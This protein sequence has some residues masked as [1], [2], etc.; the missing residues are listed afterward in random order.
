M[1]PDTLQDIEIN[2]FEHNIKGQGHSVD[3]HLFDTQPLNKMRQV[4]TTKNSFDTENIKDVEIN[5]LDHHIKSQDHNVGIP[6]FDSL[7]FPFL[8]AFTCKI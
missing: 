1:D 6:L 5:L 3:I 4:Q 2:L 8:G 7:S